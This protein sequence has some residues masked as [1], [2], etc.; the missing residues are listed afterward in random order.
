MGSIS[1]YYPPDSLT[2][3]A[4]VVWCAALALRVYRKTKD[5]FDLDTLLD[6]YNLLNHNLSQPESNF[7]LCA[8]EA[9][10]ETE[11]PPQHTLA[12]IIN[13]LHDITLLSNERLLRAETF[14]QSLIQH[15]LDKERSKTAA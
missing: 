15:L 12:E 4:H 2:Y 5:D 3:Y 14:T 1:S 9:I 7:Y 10:P 8:L 13:D 6:T 11:N